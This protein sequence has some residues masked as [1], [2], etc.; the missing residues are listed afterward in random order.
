M[1]TKYPLVFSDGALRHFGPHQVR[2]AKV[3]DITCVLFHYKFYAFSL[4]EYWQ[5][6]L[7]QKK[8]KRNPRERYKEVLETNPEIRLKRETSKEISSV[9]DL[10][11]DG[12]VIVSGDYIGWIDAQRERRPSPPPSPND[13]GEGPK[14]SK[15]RQRR[16]TRKLGG[17]GQKKTWQSSILRAPGICPRTIVDVGVGRGTPQLYEAFPKAYHVLVE[18]LKE[19]ES[20]LQNIL[21]QYDGEYFLTAVGSTNRKATI[22]VEPKRVHKSSLQERTDLTSTGDPAEK[23]EV[24]V[25]TLDTLMKEHKLQPPFGLKIDTEGFELEVVEGAAAFL[26]NTQFV[27]AE[28]SVAKRFVGGY[29]FPEF[30]EAMTRNGFFLWDIMNPGGK[31]FVDAV[32]LTSFNYQPT[33]LLLYHARLRAKNTVR[34]LKQRWI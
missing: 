15:R 16:T 24:P 20:T 31:K 5:K 2:N 13:G 3:A 26:R 14:T 10:L 21:K 4:Q 32:F 34:A 7:E 9:N 11:N 22:T 1:L 33:A 29:S 28:V 6:V 12:F 8:T 30:T 25:I 17:L 27:I 18:P 23:R 19:H